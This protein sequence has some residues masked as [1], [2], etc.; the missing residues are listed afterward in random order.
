MI[1]HAMRVS[2]LEKGKEVET[3][4]HFEEWIEEPNGEV[5]I[6]KVSFEGIH[7]SFKESAQAAF[8]KERGRVQEEMREDLRDW[9]EWCATQR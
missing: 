6:T 8:E 7:P 1:M 3:V 2:F 9:R 4:V 5:R